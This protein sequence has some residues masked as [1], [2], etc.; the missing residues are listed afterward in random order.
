MATV[1]IH[2]PQAPEPQVQTRLADLRWLPESRA[3]IFPNR[4]PNAELVM[5]KIVDELGL[6]YGVVKAMV[7]HRPTGSRPDVAVIDE[8]ARRCDW[9]IVG[10]GD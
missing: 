3:G 7:G 8:L 9:V 5:T 2:N 4:K 10:S 1:Q 6:K